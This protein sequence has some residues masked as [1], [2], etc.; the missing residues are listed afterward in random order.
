MIAT[1]P[2]GLIID[3]N[4]LPEDF[5]K[6]I[7]AAFAEYTMGTAKEY[8]FEDR[9]RFL[10]LC[11]EALHGGNDSDDI[12]MEYL[13]DKMEQDI[14][15]GDFPEESDYYSFDFMVEMY[16]MGKEHQSMYQQYCDGGRHEKEGIE[17]AITKIIRA[18]FD[19]KEDEDNESI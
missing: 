18:L 4:D 6:R 10:D 17:K 2:R 15:N 13:K 11:I 16:E 14:R 9:L 7:K 5:E 3:T 1:L 8:T 19:Y 12:V